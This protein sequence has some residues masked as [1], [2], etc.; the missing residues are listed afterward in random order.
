M[1]DKWC[2][3]C[4]GEMAERTE[5]LVRESSFR[6]TVLI[7]DVPVR[8]CATCGH[9]WLS[10]DVMRKLEALADGRQQ[11]IAIEQVPVFSLR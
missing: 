1:K 8:R 10:Q 11:P 2:A 3:L 9:R 7:K 5:T 6:G 4:G